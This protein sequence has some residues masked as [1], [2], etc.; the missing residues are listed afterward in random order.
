MKYKGIAIVK[1]HIDSCQFIILEVKMIYI[2][3]NK[4]VSNCVLHKKNLCRN[5]WETLLQ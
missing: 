4:Y 3:D 2:F 1:I 5:A